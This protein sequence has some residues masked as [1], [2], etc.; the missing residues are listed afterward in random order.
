MKSFKLFNKKSYTF[1]NNVK[2]K[3]Y[4]AKNICAC[5]WFMTCDYD[6]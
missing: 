5:D 6:S 4:K 2:I 3:I 1:R